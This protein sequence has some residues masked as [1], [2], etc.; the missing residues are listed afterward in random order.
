M[1]VPVDAEKLEQLRAGNGV[2]GAIPAVILG[3]GPGKRY[4]EGKSDRLPAGQM[5]V[6]RPG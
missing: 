1:T 4:P 2:G 3:V 6:G 5:R